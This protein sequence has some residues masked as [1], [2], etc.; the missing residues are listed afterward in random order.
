[1]TLEVGAAKAVI[2]PALPVQLAGHQGHRIARSVADDLYARVI[3]LRWHG[4][5]TFLVSCDLLW[6]EGSQVAAIRTRIGE[7]TGCDASQSFIACTHTH[8]GPDTLDWYDFAPPVDRGWLTALTESIARAAREA[9][10]VLV[11]AQL[12][13]GF[14]ECVTAVNR[15]LWK[16]GRVAREPNFSGPVD[17]RLTAML[18]RNEKGVPVACWVV[19]ALHPVILGPCSLVVSAEWCGVAARHVSQRLGCECLIWNGAAADANPL[20]W[21]GGTYEQ[22]RDVGNEIGAS[23]CAVT[24]RAVPVAADGVSARS[25]AVRLPAKPHPYLHVAQQRRQ[26][27]DGALITEVQSL[28]V[29]PITFIGLPGEC[30]CETGALL[31]RDD[32]VVVSYANDYIG[33][34]PLRHIYA[35]GGYEPHATM[36]TADGIEH[37]LSSAMALRDRG[38]A[39]DAPARE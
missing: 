34:L 19:Y 29:G 33:Y 16:D 21:T 27:R 18:A 9:V 2:T 12:S 22:V 14:G 24:E 10:R 5:L 15:R 38:R 7:L 4:R 30:L 25:V 13:F 11:P 31:R 23:A 32:C 1:V 26:Q 39:T 37:L 3:A 8:S 36:T 28:H 17:S 6:L 35:E 20:V